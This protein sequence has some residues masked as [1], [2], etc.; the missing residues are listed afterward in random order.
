MTKQRAVI[1][2]DFRQPEFW[3][4]NPEDYEFRADGKIVRKDRWEMAIRRMTSQLGLTR[5]RDFEIADVEAAVDE[6]VTL[7]KAVDD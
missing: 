1:E 4:A 7:H 3:D 5:N 6:L 2:K